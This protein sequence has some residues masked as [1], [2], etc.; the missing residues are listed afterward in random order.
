[1]EKLKPLQERKQALAQKA[2]GRQVILFHEAYDYVAEDYG[3]AVSCELDLDEERQISAGEVAEVLTAIRKD[4]ASCILAE[5][6]YGKSM[7]ETVQQEEDVT[8]VYLDPLN[9]G[10][11]DPDSYLEGMERNMELL[12]QAFGGL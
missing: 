7:A 8:V 6:L 9:R 12:E 4:G 10:D 1:M 2:A 11:Y 5:E 3:L